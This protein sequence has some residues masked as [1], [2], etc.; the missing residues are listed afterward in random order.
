MRIDAPA[1]KAKYSKKKNLFLRGDFTPF[2]TKSFQI[3]DHFFPLLF[4]K[5]SEKQKSF[6]IGFWEV[7]AQRLLNGVNK[8]KNR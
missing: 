8:G 6:Y 3:Q 7:G 2:M 4:P 5:D 1:N